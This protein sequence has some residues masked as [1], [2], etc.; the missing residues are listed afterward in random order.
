MIEQLASSWRS[1]AACAQSA[2]LH[3]LCAIV[4]GVAGAGRPLH[5][6]GSKPIERTDELSR[7]LAG[8]ARRWRVC[9]TRGRVA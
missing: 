7:R 5:L 4:A 1:A 2:Q 9:G 3:C 6:A 8:R